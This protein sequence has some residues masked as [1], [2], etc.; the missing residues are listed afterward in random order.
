MGAEENVFPSPP[1]RTDE[2]ARCT[3]R[4]AGEGVE[5]LYSYVLYRDRS[6]HGKAFFYLKTHVETWRA[7]R[8][9]A[10][11]FAINPL[12]TDGGEE[13]ALCVF[14]RITGSRSPVAPVHLGDVL[15]DLTVLAREA[16]PLGRPWRVF[17][18]NPRAVERG[19]GYTARPVG[20]PGADD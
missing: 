10:E 11:D 6:A 15:R 4:L 9:A 16:G 7:G 20:D 12:V 18:S 8:L 5:R 1:L 19:S 3:R 13:E 14:E 2:L 17:R